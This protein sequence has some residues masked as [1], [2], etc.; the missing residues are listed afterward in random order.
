MGKLTIIETPLKGLY[1]VET[2][3]FVDHRGA[4][5]RWFCEEELATTLG[6]RHIKNV[7]FSITVTTGSI[8][9]MHFQKPPHAEMK[10]VRCIRGRILDVVVDIRAGSP[11]FLEHYAIELSAENMKM[12]A[13]PEGFAHGFQSLEDDSE[14]M[15]LVT[16]FYSPESEAGLRFNDPAL[17]IEWPLPVTDIS[18]KDV[19]HPLIYDDFTGLDVSMY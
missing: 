10:L 3:A 6:K 2:N 9:G 1:I 19:E 7:N 4:F 13:I 12:F 16:E 14:I 8:R 15:Y 5:A 17:K 18:T 11:T